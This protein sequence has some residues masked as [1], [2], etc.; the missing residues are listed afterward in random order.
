MR[1]PVRNAGYLFAGEASPLFLMGRDLL[2]MVQPKPEARTSAPFV[3]AAAMAVVVYFLRGMHLVGCVGFGI[4]TYSV[5]LL[6]LNGITPEDIG[7][8]RNG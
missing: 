3:A 5:F 8:A 1:G 2:G 4:L 7:L 6:L